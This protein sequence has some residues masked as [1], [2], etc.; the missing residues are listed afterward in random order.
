MD[1]KDKILEDYIKICKEKKPTLND[2]KK[3]GHT[4]SA[5]RHHW[6][7]I[8]KLNDFVIKNNKIKSKKIIDQI[9]PEKYASKEEILNN[10]IKLCKKIKRRPTVNEIK[11]KY[12]YSRK[13]ITHHW[14]GLNNLNKYVVE[15]KLIKDKKIVE[16]IDVEKVEFSSNKDKEMIKNYIKVYNKLNK[17]PTYNDMK[18]EFDYTTKMVRH[19]YGSITNLNK[20]AREQY[21][22]KFKDILIENIKPKSENSLKKYKKFVIATVVLGCEPHM[23]FYKSIQN[24]CK[25][26]KAKLLLMI[27]A[28]PASNAGWCIDRK[29]QDEFIVEDDLKLNSNLFCSKIKLSAKHIEPTTGLDRIGQRNGSFIYAS[30]KQR[31]KLVATG[32]NK[33][34]HAIMTTG[35]I[36]KPNYTTKSFISERT[37]YIANNDHTIGAIIV[38]IEDDTVF[39]YRQIQSDLKGDFI[40][41][42]VRYTPKGHKKAK[43]EAI[44]YGDWH[45]QETDPIV[46]KTWFELSKEL[47][48]KHIIL[49]DLYSGIS[50]NY[51]ERN[52]IIKRSNRAALGQLSIAREIELMN[53]DL[54]EI[55][56]LCSKSVIVVKS[57][58]DMFLEKYL[59]SGTYINDPINHRISLELAIQL[60]DGKDPLKY[61]SEKT[62]LKN[63][64]KIEWLSRNQDY[65]I[66]KIQVGS[67]GDLGANGSRGSIKTAEKAYNN[68]ITGHTHS[69]QILRGAWCVG[70][71]TFLQLGYNE[72]HSSW[73]HTSCA[74]YENG[75]R[76]LINSIGGKWRKK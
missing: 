55:S 40:D 54:D 6:G 13:V 21:P 24:Y 64:N 73:F 38:E 1:K 17:I 30:P 66:K 51:H 58:H 41:L 4:R 60:L 71:S 11:T 32:S 5:V 19:Y 50:I 37:A 56:N 61:I 9:Q 36:T 63:P 15:N 25:K 43:T 27:S 8:T 26:N 20:V 34:P 33:L 29:L 7:S 45:S 52:D 22:D 65:F 16:K 53:K 70:T 74:L 67:H 23:G 75:Q 59:R 42:G 31:L 68:C 69:P 49:H 46:K 76:Q 35:T 2:L 39:H 57:N 62:G 3:L 12:G 48:P 44:V 28:D 10:Y 47:K 72:G 18:A 14:V